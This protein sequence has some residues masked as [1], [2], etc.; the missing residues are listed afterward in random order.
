MND[1][2]YTDVID[3]L[4]F[5]TKVELFKRQMPLWLAF[6]LAAWFAFWFYLGRVPKPQYAALWKSKFVNQLREEMPA[7]AL[8]RWAPR[9]ERLSDLG[10]C[11][12]GW[13][14]SEIIGAKQ[15]AVVLLL[16]EQGTTLAQVLWIRMMGGHGIE[17]Q[18][19][20]SFTSFLPDETELLTAALPDDQLMLT[21]VLVPDYV[22][23]CFLTE[24]VPI[25]KVY[26]R[27][28]GR[29]EMDG[30][31]TFSRDEALVQF[32]HNRVRFFQHARNAGFLRPLSPAEVEFTRGIDLP[33]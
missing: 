8:S 14:K 1:E 23:G 2:Y 9:I 5:A 24:T 28:S 27:H 6:S 4:P 20:V 17:E 3:N 29:S 13:S 31:L 19:R 25:E 16:N 18:T 11:V 33:D 12:L 32:E 7:R 26:Q 22:N 21:K 30:I 10:F 15:E